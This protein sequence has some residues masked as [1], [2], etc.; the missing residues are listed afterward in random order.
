VT[1]LLAIAVLALAAAALFLLPLIPAMVELRR[2]TDAQPLSVIQQHTGE[3]RFFA[4]SFRGYIKE[5]APVLTE[6]GHSGKALAGSLPDATQYLVLGSGREALRLPLTEADELCPV[7]PAAGVD[8]SLPPDTTFSKDIYA[9]GRFAG[10]TKNKYRAI[11]GEKAVH[12][13][14]ESS[15]MRW[16]HAVGEFTADPACELHGRVSSDC[17]IQLSRDCT[18]Q[19]LNAPRI[20]FGLE[21]TPELGETMEFKTPGSSKAPQRLLHDGDFEIAAGEI[22]R[23]NLVVR[24]TLRVGP[25]ARVWGS[26]KGD[27]AVVIESGARV[28]GS[29]VSANTMRIGA[30]CAIHGPVIAEKLIFLEKGARCGTAQTPTTVSA[31]WIEVEEGVA[32][33]G[34]LWARELGQVIAKL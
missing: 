28:E 31:P 10:G 17:G 33:F 5:L 7:L 24:G 14:A 2:K 30:S 32:V 8:L 23:G 9:G 26:V 18:F 4:D 15:V 29:L 12:L 34:T 19:R 22:F 16:V 27:E 20:E 13:G 11:L 21:P 3:I 1:S 6:A 25:G